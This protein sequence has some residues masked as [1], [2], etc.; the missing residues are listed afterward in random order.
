MLLV[1]REVS[2]RKVVRNG[3]GNEKSGASTDCDD[4]MSG[5]KSSEWYHLVESVQLHIYP[6]IDIQK[7]D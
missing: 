3:P 7:L 5:R 4:L 6:W 2:K 1:V